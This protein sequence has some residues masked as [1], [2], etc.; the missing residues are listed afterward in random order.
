MIGLSWPPIPGPNEAGDLRKRSV[1]NT[2][3]LV[4]ELC[5]WCLSHAAWSGLAP[6]AGVAVV[7]PIFDKWIL[8]N[9]YL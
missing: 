3:C 2:G 4:D 1:K 9:M 6:W 5:V 8:N 7:N